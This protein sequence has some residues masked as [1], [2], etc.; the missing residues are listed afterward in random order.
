M[1]LGHENEVKCAVFSKSGLFL[2]TCSRDKSGTVCL[3]SLPPAAGINQ[4]QC[5]SFPCHLQQG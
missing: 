2:A 1:N 4:V 5:V 3:F